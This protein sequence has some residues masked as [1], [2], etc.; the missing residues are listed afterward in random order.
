M[1]LTGTKL[2]VF[3]RQQHAS[4][5]DQ[6]AAICPITVRRV[7]L[8]LRAMSDAAMAYVAGLPREKRAA[9][10]SAMVTSQPWEPVVEQRV[11]SAIAVTRHSMSGSPAPPARGG[12][13]VPAAALAMA[14]AAEA[15][16]ATPQRPPVYRPGDLNTKI[17]AKSGGRASGWN[18]LA[19]QQLLSPREAAVVPRPTRR[20]PQSR[21][22]GRSL[23]RSST[24][25][26]Q[27]PGPRVAG[28]IIT[29][30]RPAVS[31]DSDREVKQQGRVRMRGRIGSEQR[32]GSAGQA[33][34]TTADDS[35]FHLASAVNLLASTATVTQ[36]PG[37]DAASQ[38]PLHCDCRLPPNHSGFCRLHGPREEPQQAG[39]GTRAAQATDAVGHRTPGT[40]SA[41]VAPPRPV[42]EGG[43][44][45]AKETL[46][47]QAVVCSPNQPEGAPNVTAAKPA[48]SSKRDARGAPDSSPRGRTAG[49][50][51][52]RTGQES[53]G[54]LTAEGW[55]GQRVETVDT[56][57]SA[58]SGGLSP[59]WTAVAAK[60][61]T[62]SSGPASGQRKLVRPAS[63]RS[64]LAARRT[65]A[66][67]AGKAE[68]GDEAGEDESPSSPA[69]RTAT[70]RGPRAAVDHARAT[71][72]SR[73]RVADADSPEA[74]AQP[75]RPSSVGM[76]SKNTSSL[77]SAVMAARV[78]FESSL[79]LE[80]QLKKR[81]VEKY[82]RDSPNIPMPVWLLRALQ[83]TRVEAC[84][85][86]IIPAR[87]L[88]DI[89]GVLHI[90]SGLMPELV[91]R[92]GSCD[93]GTDAVNAMVDYR[94]L[95]KA[96]FPPLVGL[97][98]P[99]EEPDKT[100]N[101]DGD[102]ALTYV[103]YSDMRSRVHTEVGGNR[104]RLIDVFRVAMDA[105]GGRRLTIKVLQFGLLT[106][107]IHV[108]AGAIKHFFGAHV[109][110]GVVSGHAVAAELMNTNKEKLAGRN[111][112]GDVEKNA[113]TDAG[114]SVSPAVSSP[115]GSA[116]APTV[117]TAAARQVAAIVAAARE[118][119]LKRLQQDRQTERVSARAAE[120]ERAAASKA[121]TEEVNG[122]LDK[123]LQLSNITEL[124]S[125][126]LA[127][128]INASSPGNQLG[129]ASRSAREQESAAATVVV[130]SGDQSETSPRI[131]QQT[132]LSQTCIVPDRKSKRMAK[133][134]R[135]L[136]QA[137][138][139]QVSHRFGLAWSLKHCH[140]VVNPS[141]M[142]GV[143]D[144]SI[145][146]LW[147][148]PSTGR[149][150]ACSEFTS[151]MLVRSDVA[152]REGGV[153]QKLEDHVVHTPV[154]GTETSFMSLDMVTNLMSEASRRGRSWATKHAGP[155][156]AE[157]PAGPPDPELPEFLKNDERSFT[158]LELSRR[159]QVPSVPEQ[160]IESILEKA[161][162][163]REAVAD[164]A[165]LSTVDSSLNMHSEQ[166]D[167]LLSRRDNDDSRGSS[168]C[169][170][171]SGRL[172]PAR[173]SMNASPG[174]SRRATGH[175][176][177]P[178]DTEMIEWEQQMMARNKAG[179]KTHL[180]GG[181][182]SSDLSAEELDD[183]EDLMIRARQSVEGLRKIEQLADVENRLSDQDSEQTA[184][185]AEQRDPAEEE[186]DE[187]EEDEELSETAQKTFSLLRLSQHPVVS[188]PNT[189][190]LNGKI[191]HLP[192]ST[193]HDTSTGSS[194]SS[195]T[196][197]L[198]RPAS[199][200]MRSR[201]WIE[202][203]LTSR[204]DYLGDGGGSRDDDREAD[205]L[206]DGPLAEDVLLGSLWL[207]QEADTAVHTV[208][209]D[210]GKQTAQHQQAAAIA[211]AGAAALVEQQE[212]W[213]QL[214]TKTASDVEEDS[215]EG[216]VTSLSHK[217]TSQPP[218]GTK[219]SDRKFAPT[220][221]KVQAGH[222]LQLLDLI[223][224]SSTIRAAI[225]DALPWPTLRRCRQLCKRMALVC[226]QAA[227]QRPQIAVLG[228]N[229][230]DTP[231][232]RV[233]AFDLPTATW[234]R[235][236]NMSS[237][238]SNAAVCTMMDGRL[239]VAGGFDADGVHQSA[240]VFD[241]V[242]GRWN[243][244]PPMSTGRSG[245]RAC[246]TLD[247]TN[248]AI[249]M[250]G[251][252]S[253]LVTIASV[254][255]Y[256]AQ[257]NS[258][259]AF[260]PLR[261]PRY[262]FSACVLPR[263]GY[264]PSQRERIVVAGGTADTSAWLKTAEVFDGNMWNLL[265][266]MSMQ[267]DRC[268]ACVLPGGG[269]AVL[270][271]S[272][273]KG[274]STQVKVHNLRTCEVYDFARDQWTDMPPMHAAR[275]N[276]GAVAVPQLDGCVAVLG[277]EGGVGSRAGA[278]AEVYH[279]RTKKWT[280]LTAMNEPRAGCGAAV[281]SVATWRSEIEQEQSEASVVARI[282]AGVSRPQQ[283]MDSPVR[284]YKSDKEAQAALY[285]AVSIEMGSCLAPDM[286]MGK[287]YFTGQRSGS[288]GEGP[289]V[290]VTATRMGGKEIMFGDGSV[291]T[292]GK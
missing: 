17:S 127:R 155:V 213:E 210:A 71:Q 37:A 13:C 100:V 152:V 54:F 39:T 18:A 180:F 182:S 243:Q 224:F 236:P 61:S 164:A 204:V 199:A 163:L 63:G 149:E 277:G 169:S 76:S 83:R 226:C 110:G 64:W 26:A 99:D 157:F 252:D 50:T 260:P 92:F 212:L 104:S 51:A 160:Q 178:Q 259:K 108:T 258:W 281:L 119:S 89:P 117:E 209:A 114:G 288:C 219:T 183:D 94:Q 174:G 6:R 80:E 10:R 42:G 106:L 53:S 15:P 41:P 45:K 133:G 266:S 101:G 231:T 128:K 218:S 143:S 214:R 228:G 36:R 280:V 267:R 187:D 256:D 91:Q 201:R 159:P 265:P 188:S 233:T 24:R 115:D 272:I 142:E 73:A 58:K 130:K 198:A 60:R 195:R 7:L 227:A 120:Q 69:V 181:Y 166:L 1:I 165:S 237:A 43:V 168:A 192:P 11:R 12:W 206:H 97:H 95:V 207:A 158:R 247:S 191:V 221:P 216:G 171:S 14:Q 196:K 34:T 135:N 124:H 132:E 77:R 86:N 68:L 286:L 238:R 273:T 21:R 33:R 230:G 285:G 179:K 144:S 223:M 140:S 52:E 283:L 147:K 31:A 25:V 82:R 234:R 129:T 173:T 38:C 257:T 193:A 75:A 93:S 185:G 289:V 244:L 137:W 190:Q 154:A 235:L 16:A 148:H 107:R 28:T 126:T 47:Q 279:P 66:T 255:C 253:D 246:P 175:F 249:V 278:T 270:G 282:R 40:T 35:L 85:S 217:P 29:P 251:Y 145:Q 151:Q 138:A 271:G 27:K 32:P 116:A 194:N 161:K 118:K 122:V 220:W 153:L 242:T 250:G 170:G 56:T 70:K 156:V 276:F 292:I 19:G 103:D 62:A 30:N 203:D 208:S 5:S 239:L 177:M 81:I 87:C 263:T 211:Q 98:G 141:M 48:R 8:G 275:C 225:L 3:A 20:Q 113:P 22:S 136:E 65:A 222:K 200:P 105:F 67:N 245:C 74:S 287:R 202:K 49:L 189:F 88:Q 57:I 9:M 2:P 102:Q 205:G 55:V 264:L 131:G 134:T 125:T 46:E 162:R 23:S 4:G 261:S 139:D 150:C 269:V 79:S 197:Q 262:D 290:L 123:Y 176:E 268:G 109:S 229:S 90:P 248:G 274:D 84:E 72:A 291:G 121:A 111:G 78:G 284:F 112:Q 241:P 184:S 44:Q 215:T 59:G 167:D 240:E 146:A 186:E 232:A 96:L 172:S 254:E